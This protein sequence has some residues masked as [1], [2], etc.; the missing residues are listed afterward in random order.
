MTPEEAKRL[1][2]GLRIT[3]ARLRG[4]AAE[5]ERLLGEAVERD[6]MPRLVEGFIYVGLTATEMIAQARAIPLQEA[7]RGL[8]PRPEVVLI[9]DVTVGSW[10]DIIDLASAVRRSHDEA[11]QM[12]HTMD[13]P[14]AIN[15]SFQLAI[16]ALTAMSRVPQFRHM[17]PAQITEMFIEGVEAG[18]A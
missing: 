6:E 17:S 12:S 16:S 13:V 5:E 4:N 10:D 1:E 3:A 2:E 15:V 7:L 8:S 11:R 14:G 9:P 18:H